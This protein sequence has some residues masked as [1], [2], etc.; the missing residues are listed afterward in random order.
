MNNDII[1]PMPIPPTPRP[2]LPTLVKIIKRVITGIKNLFKGQAKEAGQ[3]DQKESVEN[4][5][6]LSQIFADMREQARQKTMEI[7]G[8]VEKE[9]DYYIEELHRILEDNA[10]KMDKYGIRVNRTNRQIDRIKSRL[11]GVIDHEIS[12]T[13]SFDNPECNRIIKMIP[14]AKKEEAM[15]DFFEDSF[16][17]AIDVYWNEFKECLK[18]IFEDVDNEINGAFEII[19]KNNEQLQNSFSSIDENNF[20]ETAKEQMME[21]YYISDMCDMVL[22]EIK[23]G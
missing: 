11:K 18:D 15:G 16:K 6:R 10:D 23:E 14:G 13:V 7:E 17:K 20:E 22:L 3:V 1:N 21:A 8:A 12:R 4:V 9:V 19:Q 2:G 5:D